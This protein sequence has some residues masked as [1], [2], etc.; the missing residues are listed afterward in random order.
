LINLFVTSFSELWLVP[1]QASSASCDT[2]GDTFWAADGTKLRLRGTYPKTSQ[3]SSGKLRGA[4][5]CPT[6]VILTVLGSLLGLG[7]HALPLNVSMVNTMSGPLTA[8]IGGFPGRSK[9]RAENTSDGFFR[10]AKGAR[11]ASGPLA[12]AYSPRKQ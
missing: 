2:F 10:Q 5:T 6:A 3:L 4:G 11:S 8:A 1:H 9:K 12:R 7:G